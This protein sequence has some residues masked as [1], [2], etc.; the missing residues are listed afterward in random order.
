MTTLQEV[1][2]E[3]FTVFR[4]PFAGVKPAIPAVNQTANQI[5]AAGWALVGARGNNS[6]KR[7]GVKLSVTPEFQTYR[8]ANTLKVQDRWIVSDEAMIEF[9]L[10]DV[11]HEVLALAL[12]QNVT[13]SGAGATKY[14]EIGLGHPFELQRNSWLLYGRSPESVAKD[15]T[16]NRFALIW[17]GIIT[18]A[19]E[20]M[21]SL[22]APSEI[23]FKVEPISLDAEPEVSKYG[24]VRTW[25]A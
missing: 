11:S 18:S 14:K 9:S 6:V 1:I 2:A 20:D 17:D 12:H 23:P 3:P 25:A 21:P 19:Y 7:E 8:G 10:V 15:V 13:T 22:D 4:R 5:I 16:K 24:I